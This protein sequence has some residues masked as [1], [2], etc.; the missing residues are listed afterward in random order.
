MPSANFFVRLGLFAIP[1]F[2]EPELCLRL[3]SEMAS[4]EVTQATLGDRDMRDAY[5]VD[6]SRR[7]SRR[8]SIRASAAGLLV[9]WFV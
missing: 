4:S 2:L 9:T 1:G 8:A 6:E 3:R 7:R 5:G